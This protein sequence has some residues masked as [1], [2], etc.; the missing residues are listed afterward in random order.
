MPVR[1]TSRAATSSA[2]AAVNPAAAGAIVGASFAPAA[3]AVGETLREH[4]DYLDLVAARRSKSA[5]NGRSGK[6]SAANRVASGLIR[7]VKDLFS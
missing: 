6:G 7:A 1:A 4:N 2:V 3:L 5:S